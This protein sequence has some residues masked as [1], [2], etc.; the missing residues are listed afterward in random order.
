MEFAFGDR[1]RRAAEITDNGRAGVN[2]DSERQPRQTT[3][4]LLTGRFFLF[5]VGMK[6]GVPFA[7]VLFPD[8][9][10]IVGA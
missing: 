5:C 4:P 8:R 2:G 9:P 10:G 3:A 7:I 6:D 1:P